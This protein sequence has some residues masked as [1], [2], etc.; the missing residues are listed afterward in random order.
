MTD[1]QLKF[2]VTDSI[3]ISG[4]EIAVNLTSFFVN[5]LIT[6]A[7]AIYNGSAP[8]IC[9]E[10]PSCQYE[11]SSP[12]FDCNKSEYV[13]AFRGPQQLPIATALAVST[14]IL[15]L[16]YMACV[17]LYLRL[18]IFYFATFTCTSSLF[19]SSCALFSLVCDSNF[20]WSNLKTDSSGNDR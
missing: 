20:V 15:L 4:D 3:G 17:Q 5:T 1:S 8:Q 7:S 14:L 2:N 9:L 11:P 19:F 13:L 18:S 16:F 10:E 6:N 12:C